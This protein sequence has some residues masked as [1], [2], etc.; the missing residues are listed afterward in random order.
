MIKNFYR[1]IGTSGQALHG[2]ERQYK[3]AKLRK[4]GF[5]ARATLRKI[6][7]EQ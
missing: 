5:V 1:Y 2:Y 7:V 4:Q 6:Y 3:G